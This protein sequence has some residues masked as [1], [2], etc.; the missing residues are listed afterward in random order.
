M[1][2]LLFLL[3]IPLLSWSQ[4]P[5]DSWASDFTVTDIN[6]NEFNLYTTLDEGKTV[7]LNLFATWCEPCYGFG[8]TSIL[9][10]V[11]D[12]YPDDVVCIAI[13]A[14]PSTPE[15]TIFG[16]DY[17]VGDFSNM[18]PLIADDPTGNIAEDYA[19]SYYPTTY[20]ICPD[21]MVTELGQV[22]IDIFM[23]EINLCS[24]AQYSKDAKMVSYNGDT[25]MCEGDFNG[26]VIIQNYGLDTLTAC[27]IL[28]IAD[29]LLIDTY[30]WTGSLVTYQSDTVDLGLISGVPAGSEIIFSIDYSG[31]IYES[32]N[33]INPVL[34]P[35]QESS[36]YVSLKILTDYWPGE[37]SW[38]LLDP[39]GNIL[40]S[41]NVVFQ[42][43]GALN[44]DYAGAPYTE[45]IFDWELDIIPGCYRFNL[46]DSYGDGVEG[47]SSGQSDGLITLTDLNSGNIFFSAV[48]FG[49]K[50]SV[51]FSIDNSNSN[52]IEELVVKKMIKTMD[53]LGRNINT[54]HG[55]QLEI[56]DDGSIEKKYILE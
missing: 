43:F 8:S 7:I 11:Q 26:S 33:S 31:D 28:T 17:S 25:H 4:L 5:P 23:S 16:E 53:L 41:T 19:L 39:N 50:S 6:G 54:K 10:D 42:E 12:A 44:G 55:F 56:Y 40:E 3:I 46:Y 30:N 52:L 21:R 35:H 48:N 20:K 13:E 29:D 38:E 47:S 1:K 14:D 36:I 15:N 2:K 45:F 18:F 27:N 37:T 34:V 22:S 9:M 49:F 32:N 51:N 24:S